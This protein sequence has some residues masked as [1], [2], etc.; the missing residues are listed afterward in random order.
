MKWEFT[1]G[2]LPDTEQGGFQETWCQEVDF[3]IEQLWED[4]V[5][6]GLM[7]VLASKSEQEWSYGVESAMMYY[8]CGLHRF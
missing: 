1:S 7:E 3:E 5:V 4:Q 2:F 6:S 8:I